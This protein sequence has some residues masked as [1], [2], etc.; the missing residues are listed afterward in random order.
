MP[1]SRPTP[2][3]TAKGPAPR[4][5]ASKGPTPKRPA[6]R[7]PT[8]RR[9]L[10]L[11]LVVGVLVLLGLLVSAILSSEPDTPASDAQVVRENSHVLNQATDE[12]AVLVEF[13]DLECEACRAY[14]PAVEQLR[15]EHADE[16]TLVMRYFPLPGH[17]NSTNAAVA[18]EAAAA[19]GQLKP[20]YQR[21][22]QTQTE[23][24]EAQ[25]SKAHVFRDFAQD[26]GL[27]MDAYDA[28]VADPA[29]TARVQADFDEGRALGVSTTPTFFLD[30]ERLE[31]TS[32][33]HLAEAVQAALEE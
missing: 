13:L 1:A 11:A 24:G 2:R 31:V 30:G 7:G 3:P 12:K 26:L 10:Q 25:E 32:P 29:T 16:L 18:V 17:T 28:A 15:E 14:F 23:W 6:G 33:A 22:Y 27:D 4:R 19:Q 5:P 9:L 20:M 8:A 21:M